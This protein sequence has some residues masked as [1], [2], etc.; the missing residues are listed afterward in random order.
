[1]KLFLRLLYTLIFARFRKKIEVN[2]VCST[3]FRVWPTDLDVLKHVNNGVYF[4]MMDLGRIDMMFRTGMYSCVTKNGWY[5]VVTA[6]TL[7]F[8]KSLKLFQKFNMHT[9]VVGWDEKSF[10]IEQS[11]WVE[12]TLYASGVVKGRFLK[13]KGGQVS[14]NEL[15]NEIGVDFDKMDLR[16]SIVEW[17]AAAET[18]FRDASLK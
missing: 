11:F 16:P 17:S 12:G 8:K 6:E 3:P 7:R 1:M 14:T 18:I 10:Y 2:G 15:L 4:T 13:K 9:Q 5:P